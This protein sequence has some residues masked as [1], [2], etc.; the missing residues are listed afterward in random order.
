M[1]RAVRYTYD[2]LRRFPDDGKRRELV[3]GDI[4]VAPSPNLQHQRIVL[5]LAATILAYLQ[6]HPL[7][8]VFV[9]PTDVVFASGD[10]VIPDVVY[11]SRERAAIL[12]P[13]SIQGAP[14]WLIEV[15]SP[16][17]RQRDVTL[18]LALYRA[19]GVHLYWMIDAEAQTVD[20]WQKDG[21]H[22]YM[23][24]EMVDVPLLPGLQLQVDTILTGA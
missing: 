5:G 20:V 15:A 23:P 11:V 14:D 21:H 2:D 4:V 12:T 3:A 7:G 1:S 16:S 18:K 9:A 19:Q 13:G 17:T 10:V 22:S 6:R 24:G 8:E